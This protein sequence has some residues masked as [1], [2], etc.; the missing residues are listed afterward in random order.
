[1]DQNENGM[2]AMRFPAALCLYSDQITSFFT[3]SVPEVGAQESGCVKI[4]FSSDDLSLNSPSLRQRKDGNM[5]NIIVFLSQN[6]VPI[7]H[8]QSPCNSALCL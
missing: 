5:V 8:H 2:N 3:D 7:A 4:H 6:N 1:M